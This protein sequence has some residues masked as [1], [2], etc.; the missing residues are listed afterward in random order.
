MTGRDALLSATLLLAL[1]CVLQAAP[2]PARDGLKYRDFDDLVRCQFII[3]EV[4]ARLTA[5]DRKGAAAFMG[6]PGGPDFR[7]LPGNQGQVRSCRRIEI[8]AKGGKGPKLDVDSV[9]LLRY[10]A[11]S[12]Q[13]V[14]LRFGK[15]ERWTCGYIS[16]M[17]ASPS[18]FRKGGRLYYRYYIS[19]R[20]VDQDEGGVGPVGPESGLELIN[21]LKPERDDS[22]R[23]AY[24]QKVLEQVRAERERREAETDPL[25]RP[26]IQK[27]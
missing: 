4:C 10:A 18:T 27:E 9:L 24:L 1:P 2:V 15:L 5:G 25:N 22:P 20:V 13:E 26:L 19:T 17:F 8:P 11:G 14:G 12:E 3:D 21:R 23:S 7:D 6:I 16:G